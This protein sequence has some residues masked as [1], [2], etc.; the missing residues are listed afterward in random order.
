MKKI[1]ASA[2]M[3][4]FSLLSTAAFASEFNLPGLSLKWTMGGHGS[5]KK[6]LHS[7]KN[8]SNMAWRTGKI[9]QQYRGRPQWHDHYS[10]QPG[11]PG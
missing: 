11:N 10:G 9:V 4:G 5:L 7:W 6:A 1:I 3:R 8:S 2:A